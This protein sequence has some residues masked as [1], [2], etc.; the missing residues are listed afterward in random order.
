MPSTHIERL[1][2]E[3]SEHW[4]DIRAA[5]V[6]AGLSRSEARGEANARLGHPDHLAA[7]IIDGIRRRSWLGRH[8]FVA[9]CVL[10]LL[11]APMLMALIA[12]PL[13]LL[14]GWIHFTHW[15]APENKPN[16][17]LITGTLWFLHYTTMIGSLCWVGF[18][19]WTAGLGRKW[20]LA[21]CLW[22]MVAALLRYFDADPIKRNVVVSFGFPWRLNVHTAIVL[23]VHGLACAG[24][25]F[26]V[27]TTPKQTSHNIQTTELV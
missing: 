14:D 2:R 27:K 7:N 17:Y 6:R 4:E 12:F 23:L 26:A 8:P 22:C 3:L 19:A 11:L 1:T 24:F 9:L 18:R 20:V 25:L 10:P 21:F 5:A 16:A 15:G 13:A